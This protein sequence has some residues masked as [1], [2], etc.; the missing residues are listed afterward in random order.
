[1]IVVSATWILWVLFF[2][3]KDTYL[4]ATTGQ[5]RGRWNYLT[6]APTLIRAVTPGN[7]PILGPTRGLPSLTVAYSYWLVTLYV[8]VRLIRAGIMIH[9]YKNYRFVRRT[10]VIGMIPFVGPWHVLF[11]LLGVKLYFTLGEPQIRSRF[12]APSQQ[13]TEIPA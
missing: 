12:V 9:R 6:V 4:F 1:M 10:I 5:M 2:L 11:W 3:G 13:E 8:S 7:V